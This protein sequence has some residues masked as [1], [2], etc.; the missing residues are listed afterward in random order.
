MT[1]TTDSIP[2]PGG[3]TLPSLDAD[4]RTAALGP[5]A[6]FDSRDNPFYP[7]RGTQ[8]HGLVSF[9]GE[10][11]GGRRTY[12]G[13][14]AWLNRYHAMGPR[15]VLAWHASAC[16]V[17]GAAPFYDL[18]MLGKSQDLR[19][20]TIGQYRDR[21]ML[22]AQ[23]EWRSELWWRFGATAFFGEGVVA[24]DFGSLTWDNLLPGGGAGLRFTLAERESRQPQ[25]RL[26]M[27]ERQ[28]CALHRR[29]RGVLEVPGPG[30]A[31][32]QSV[33][34]PGYF[35]AF[36]FAWRS[37]TTAIASSAVSRHCGICRSSAL[38][39]ARR[40]SSIAVFAQS[41]S[42]LPHLAHE[43]QRHVVHVTHLQELPDHQHLEHGADAAW[44]DDE[45]VRGEHEMMEAREE[46]L[47]LEGLLDKRVHVLFERQLDTDADRARRAGCC[48]AFVG[49]L[50]QP[51]AAAGHD[52]A[53]H[54]RQTPPP[55]ASL[56]RRRTVPGLR[57]GRA[58]NRH[59]IPVALRGAE[60]GEVVHDLPQIEN[61][62]CRGFP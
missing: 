33:V 22:A 15:N 5:R 44:D 51:G 3:P 47:V 13:Y 40:G 6:D 42:P 55:R 4:I 12:Q 18:C 57:A 41:M 32:R 28:H 2:I 45:R 52:V 58:E 8:L 17:H 31:R 36:H 60:P 30:E 59:A 56:R 26:R 46:R 62:R 14:Q 27:G 16:G 29:H 39:S 10:G 35:L 1:V 38:A 23:A 49:R 54:R 7:R 21:A 61:G 37:R 11:V 53:A 24:Q 25:G 48:R 9:Y 50:H 43:N 20:Y 34:D 19:G